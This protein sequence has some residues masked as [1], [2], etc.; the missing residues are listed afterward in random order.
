MYRLNIAIFLPTGSLLGSTETNLGD[1]VKSFSTTIEAD[2][3]SIRRAS[4]SLMPLWTYL[5]LGLTKLS[6]TKFTVELADRT[7][8]YPKGIAKNVL[9]GIDLNVPLELRID[10]ID[11][12]MPIIEEGEVIDEPMIDIIKAR[13]NESFDEYP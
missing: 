9:V 12:S 7:V 8:K 2:M 4:V 11:D 10:Q 5:N 1:H 6:H 3:T 13:K